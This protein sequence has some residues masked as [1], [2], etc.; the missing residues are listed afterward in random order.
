MR[1]PGEPGNVHPPSAIAAKAVQ[2]MLAC[3]ASFRPLPCRVRALQRLQVA[4]SLPLDPK[5]SQSKCSFL[6]EREREGH[7]NQCIHFIYLF[8]KE[9]IKVHLLQLLLIWFS[10]YETEIMMGMNRR[11]RTLNPVSLLFFTVNPQNGPVATPTRTQM[12]TN[13]E[14]GKTRKQKT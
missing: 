3:P 14:E 9:E 10:Q 1:A 4:C 8:F 2:A 13:Q 7:S 6:R 12:V 5:D 11:Q